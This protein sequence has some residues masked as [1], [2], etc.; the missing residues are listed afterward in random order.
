MARNWLLSGYRQMA[1]HAAVVAGFGETPC[2]VRNVTSQGGQKRIERLR[3]VNPA[4][5]YYRYDIISK[6]MPVSQ[7]KG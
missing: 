6:Q 3:E 4:E 2:S 1:S 5:H 7:Y